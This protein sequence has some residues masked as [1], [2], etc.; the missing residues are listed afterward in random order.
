MCS[1]APCGKTAWI[2]ALVV[3]SWA[4]SGPGT[5]KRP[6]VTDSLDMIQSPLLCRLRGGLRARRSGLL[7]NGVRAR[8]GPN[9]RDA[10]RLL[11]VLR[12]RVAMLIEALSGRIRDT[13]H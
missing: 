8:G 3:A 12:A 11:Q 7:W 1:V 6:L 9:A 5:T 10:R 4:S 13:S 2:A